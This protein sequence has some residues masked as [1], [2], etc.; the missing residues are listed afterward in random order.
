MEHFWKVIGDSHSDFTNVD[1]TSIWTVWITTRREHSVICPSIVR[2]DPRKHTRS[3]QILDTDWDWWFR[4]KKG[5]K[6]P[7]T[8]E[9][10]DNQHRWWFD[11]FDQP[12]MLIGQ[13]WTI[14]SS[15]ITNDHQTDN[16]KK[17]WSVKDAFPNFPARCEYIVYFSII[18][19]FLTFYLFWLLYKMIP[20]GTR[21][22]SRI[23]AAS[24]CSS[25]Q[26]LGESTGT[27]DFG[28]LGLTWPCWFLKIMV[29]ARNDGEFITQKVLTP[30]GPGFWQ[31][32][33]TCFA[34]QEAHFG[35]FQ[36]KETLS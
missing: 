13:N 10:G 16:Y 26:V 17:C 9:I 30:T 20:L 18:S 6:Q 23:N 2:V 5:F 35:C 8:Q 31:W 29:W 28:K 7:K 36:L 34:G 27:N 12:N 25:A 32:K 24:P 3:I 14:S 4:K 21:L 11:Q 15:G 1:C 33:A 22:P 19:K